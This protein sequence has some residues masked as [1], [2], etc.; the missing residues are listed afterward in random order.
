MIPSNI[1]SIQVWCPDITDMSFEE[2]V[3]AKV[4]FQMF[5]LPEGIVSENLRQTFERLMIDTGLLI[6]PN[7]GQNRTLYSLRSTYATFA[8]AELAS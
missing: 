6:S 4:D 7:T 1:V 5:R 3:K 2:L 8:L